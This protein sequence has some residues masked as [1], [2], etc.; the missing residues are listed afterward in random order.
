MPW[1]D[2]FA[3]SVCCTLN[4]FTAA[5][6][7]FNSYQKKG[8]GRSLSQLVIQARHSKSNPW[9]LEG[10]R[11]RLKSNHGGW[12][13][14]DDSW[15]VTDDGWRSKLFHKKETGALKNALDSAF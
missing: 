12:G 1:C 11:R 5:V 4:L 8:L 15:R 2:P 3:L 13:V 6:T 7:S 9:R 10:N 14:A